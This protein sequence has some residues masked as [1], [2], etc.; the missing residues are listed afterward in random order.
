M[1]PYP[2]SSTGKRRQFISQHWA[3]TWQCRDC[4]L[5][6]TPNYRSWAN[7]TERR[8]QNIKIKIRL[9]INSG[10]YRTCDKDLLKILFSFR[11][12]QNAATR[13][14]PSHL[15]LGWTLPRPGDWR[16]Q[17]HDDLTIQERH[18]REEG[19]KYRQE[20]YQQWYTNQ[21]PIPWFHPGE[22]VY[23]TSKIWPIWTAIQK[24]SC[25]DL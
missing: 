12:R 25:V 21:T 19:A 7:P 16:L 24:S 4:D 3:N 11:R 20:R 14:T 23:V 22:Q 10:N 6:T 18:E 15:L 1:G 8:N 17:E 5:W 13:Q 9:R 2:P